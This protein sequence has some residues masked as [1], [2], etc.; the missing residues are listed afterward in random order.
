VAAEHNDDAPLASRRSDNRA[1]D[2]PEV[3]GD[4]NIRK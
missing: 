1:N 3:A 2:V 4:E